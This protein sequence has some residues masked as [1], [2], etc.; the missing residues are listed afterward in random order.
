ME[1]F[2]TPKI[3]AL[4]PHYDDPHSLT[5]VSTTESWTRP[6]GIG[7]LEIGLGMGLD[8]NIELGLVKSFFPV[9]SYLSKHEI[10]VTVTL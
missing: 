2:P 4:G 1:A 9:P 3:L 10:Y 8:L 5:I 6:I 7:L